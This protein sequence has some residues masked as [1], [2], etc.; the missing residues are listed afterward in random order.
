MA[1]VLVQR[2][3]KQGDIVV[4]GAQ[5]G[6]VRS[7]VDDEG[8][9]IE[10]AGPS[11]A[12]ELIGLSGLP[13]AGDQLT[14]TA[15]DTKARELARH[16]SSSS[17]SAARRPLRRTLVGRAVSLPIRFAGRSAHEAARLRDQGGRQGPGRPSRPP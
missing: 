15:D 16:A 2:G 3:T 11:A 6:R 1:T 5:W 12:V 4:A 7:L 9:R 13:E 17:A 8:G 10:S 14:V